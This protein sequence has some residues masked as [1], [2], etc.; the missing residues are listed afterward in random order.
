MGHKLTDSHTQ[1]NVIDISPKPMV[2]AA[3]LVQSFVVGQDT[4]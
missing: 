4:M 2:L 1:H 3:F